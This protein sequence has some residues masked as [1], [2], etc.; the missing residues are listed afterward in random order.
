VIIEASPRTH[1]HPVTLDGAG[2][3][4]VRKPGRLPLC[5]AQVVAPTGG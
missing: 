5:A 4:G 1:A 3:S 2:L